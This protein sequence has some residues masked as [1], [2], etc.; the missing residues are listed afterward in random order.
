MT[1]SHKRLLALCAASL[2]CLCQA[3]VAEMLYS[4]PPSPAR[5]NY[6]GTIGC[7]FRVGSSNVVVSHL[8]VFDIN[9]DGLIVAHQA[10]LF[11]SNLTSP[12]LLGSV[13]VPSGTSAYLTN[14]FRWMPLD[15]PV[16]LISNMTYVVAG[17]VSNGD[18]DTWQDAFSP[19]WNTRFIGTNAAASQPAY[20]P[21]DDSW[22]AANFGTFGSAQTYGNVSLA[23]IEVGLPHVGVQETN[24]ALS[25]GQTLSVLGFA[26][27]QTPVTYQWF[28]SPGSP[29]AGQT[30]ALLD[31]PNASTSDSGTYYLT[32]S[33]AL[34]GAQSA[35]VTVLVTGFPVGITQGPTN[36]T[37]FAQYPAAFSLSATGSP[38]IF[39]QWFRNGDAVTGAT[40]TNYT[41]ATASPTNN[42]D[43]YFCIASNNISGT[44]YADTSSS[45][46]LTVVPN[47]A[48]PQAF[49]HGAKPNTATNNFS[50]LVGGTFTVGNN[51]PLVT[52]LGYYA[53]QFTDAAKTNAMLSMDHHVG[54]FSADGSVLYGSVVVSAGTHEVLNG[55]MW[56][57][58]DIPLV[59][60]S[61]TT[62]LL[63]AETFSGVD[64]WGDTY[65]VSDLNPNFASSSA[66]TYWGAS[67]PDAGAAGYFSGQMYSAPNMAVLAL[68]TPSAFVGPTTVT[69]Y[70]GFDVT[71]TATVAGEAPVTLQWFKDG[72]V[73]LTGQTNR[74]LTLSGVSLG[75]SGNYYVI[76]TN[77]VTAASAQSG[78][79]SVTIIPAVGPSITQD[80]Q[81]QTAY[82]HQT[83]QF[84]A[85]AEGT[86]SLH[87]QWSF[88][89]TPIPGETN[90]VLTLANVS[91]PS[92]GN[93]QLTVTNEYG[94]TSTSVAG[95][96]VV[97]P[98]W[99]S[100][101]SA[102][103]SANLLLYYR[104]SDVYSGFGIA[105][106]QGSLGIS[107][108]GMYENCAGAD[109]PTNMSH[110]EVGNLA[111]SPTWP[112]GDVVVP[113]LGVTVGNATIAAWVYKSVD[114]ESDAAIYFHRGANV[115]GLSVTGGTNDLRYTWNGTYYTF[116]SGLTLPTNQWVLVALTV[117]PSNAT[118]Y[119]QDGTGLRM[120]NN[121]ASHPTQMFSATNY[122]GWDTAGGD[123]GRRWDGLIDELMI[124]D[125][126][127]SPTEVN[128]L[129]LGVPGSA[130]LTVAP[131]GNQLKLTWPGGKL[132]EAAEITGPWTTNNAATSPYM[133]S[134]TGAKKFYRVQLQP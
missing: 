38:P 17:H 69:Q 62:Y 130:T 99:G 108:S 72:G 56:T 12:T 8:G 122:V 80:I 22:P 14:G 94:S 26:S 88:N 3:Q 96:T 133:V 11:D 41:I 89:S 82:E 33:N 123:I 58:L 36:L 30:N 46:T 75:D 100:Y 24:I 31:M 23:F 61:N 134:P 16:L 54:I 51:T 64:P 76:A 29:L 73:K 124:F 20:G 9:D 116:D 55:Y 106:N 103:M 74:A 87:Y 48:A 63:I 21:G 107:Y 85:S 93:Y 101:P 115:F 27:G 7:K 71:L 126:D 79:A 118:L 37:V 4:T 28:K 109:G 97:V 60:S 113:P 91:T 78:N 19:T 92:A 111:V 49:L 39:Y 6:S 132:L 43:T 127:L 40:A 45:A 32:A 44:G 15:P 25:A 42:G 112:F 77:V 34:G 105:T 104:F 65:A 90:S 125:R 53:S 66:A 10:G 68:S 57:P 47:F 120:T 59:L 2:T 86:P 102:V 84:T 13:V 52:H 110:F 119:L 98:T 67:W 95:L 128:A 117:N 114:Q 131:V 81:S 83:V 35:N 50:G 129:Y 70:V 121:A 18:G 1:S 5:N